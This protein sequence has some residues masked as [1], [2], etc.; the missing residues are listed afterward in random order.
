MALSRRRVR[1]GS[2]CQPLAGLLTDNRYV[3]GGAIIL[4]GIGG[5]V[6]TFRQGDAQFRREWGRSAGPGWWI[7]RLIS[8]AP[9][10]SAR[11]LSFVLSLGITALGIAALLGL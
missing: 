8:K 7:G 11:A 6:M 4:V 2:H 5:F 3:L 1:R 9:G 10:A